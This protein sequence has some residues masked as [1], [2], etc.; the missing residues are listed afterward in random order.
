MRVRDP[1]SKKRRLLTAAL[2]EFAAHGLS[3]GRIDAIAK[4]AGCSS[5]LVYTYF[6]SKERLF[7]AVLAFI[8]ESAV[9]GMPITGDDLPGYAE[10]LHQGNQD[11]PEVVR[12]VTWYQLERDPGTDTPPM[13]DDTVKH[14]IDVVRQ[15][16]KDGLVRD[17][18]PAPTLL[19]AV[20]AIARMW[21]TH[22]RST[23]DAIDPTAD[24]QL[25]REAVRAAVQALVAV[26]V[27]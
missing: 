6:G 17:D 20:Q 27:S 21:T 25:R 9:A 8:A 2:T 16:Q 12:F 23:L 10:K 7:D 18:I 15:A 22:P 26:P 1:D 14:K 13:P 11:H 24:R 19:L 4:G 5:G 3:G